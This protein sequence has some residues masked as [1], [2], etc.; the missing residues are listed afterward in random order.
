[1]GLF[2]LNKKLTFARQN[3]F[4]FNQINK[5]TINFYSYRRYIN[6]S[7]Y[8]LFQIPIMHPHFLK[9]LPK[10][11]EYIQI[12]C[13]DLKNPFVFGCRRWYLYNN[14]QC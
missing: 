5:L 1:M 4:I 3:C 6:I 13:N 10:N 11:P 12:H 8:L 2:E 7:S 9:I 14:P